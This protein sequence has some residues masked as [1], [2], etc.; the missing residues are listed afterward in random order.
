[1]TLAPCPICKKPAEEKWK[2]FCS[3]R[4]SQVDLG[5]WFTGKY[6]IE[7]DERPTETPFEKEGS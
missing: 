2:P 4:C 7:T 3:E 1:M 5:N 6:R